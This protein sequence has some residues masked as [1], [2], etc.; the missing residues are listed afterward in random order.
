MMTFPSPKASDGLRVPSR[1]LSGR[2]RAPLRKVKQLGHAASLSSPPISEV[3]TDGAS[4]RS[5]FVT[6]LSRSAQSG[7]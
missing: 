6:L 5:P 7:T 2:V 4:T 3:K 1:F